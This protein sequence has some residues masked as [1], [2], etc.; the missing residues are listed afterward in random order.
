MKTKT[1]YS[2]S[3]TV[4]EYNCENT[5]ALDTKAQCHSVLDVGS[6]CPFVVS[7]KFQVKMFPI[8]TSV[9]PATYGNERVIMSVNGKLE[10]KIISP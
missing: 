6:M 10:S 5:S 8:D 1:V 4:N 7:A 3:A 2:A 9:T